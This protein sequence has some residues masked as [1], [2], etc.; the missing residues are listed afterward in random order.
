MKIRAGASGFSYKPWKGPFYPEDIADADML[1]YYAERLPS[2]EINNTFYRLPNADVLAGWAEKT[3]DTFRFVLKASRRITHM[4]RLKE[5]AEPTEYLFKSAEALGD[6]LGPVLFQ[7]PPNMKRDDERLAS[8]LAV[9][10]KGKP[11]T[12]EFRHESW[13]DDAV[14]EMLRGHN[15]ALC[16]AE[17]PEKEKSTPLEATADWGYLRLRRDD[18]DAR[19]LRA[20]AKKIEKQ[21]W[22]EAWVFFK[23]EDEG[24]APK[25]ATKMMELLETQ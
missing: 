11:V 21:P 17:F 20:W 12:F 2:V 24:A 18:Y 9:L 19:R 25:L 7:L 6:K 5:A 4:K 15:A 8:F 22:R 10:P 14:Y 23:H 16:A 1:A 13:F 3:P